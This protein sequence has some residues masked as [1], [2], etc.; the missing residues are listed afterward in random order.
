MFDLERWRVGWLDYRRLRFWA[1]VLIALYGFT[2]FVIVPWLARDMI[3]N[4][5]RETLGLTAHL[6]DVDVNPF[7]LS[8]R[9]E[10]FALDDANGETLLSCESLEAN[11]ELSSLFHR[12]FTFLYVRIASPYVN[13]VIDEHNKLNLA[14]LAPTTDAAPA[15]GGAEATRAAGAPRVLVHRVE[16]LGGAM[17]LEDHA[18]R[19]R[20]R[21]RFGPIDVIVDDLSTLPNESGEQ[22]VTIVG[23]SGAKLDWRGTVSLN[24]IGSTGHLSLASLLLPKLSAY[25]SDA[26]DVAIDDGRM[27]VAF[28]YAL[29][30]RADGKIGGDVTD[31]DVAVQDLVVTR[32]MDDAPLASLAALHIENGRVQWPEQAVSVGRVSIAGPQLHL[33]RDA[34]GR[35]TWN[36]LMRAT[37]NALSAQEPE[38]V[39][40][41]PPPAERN[42]WQLAIADV[43]MTGGALQFTDA[44][45]ASRANFGVE[46]VSANLHSVSLAAD[47]RMPF[48]LAFGVTG[49][50]RLKASGTF[51]FNPSLVAESRVEADSLALPSLQPYVGE[52]T[53]LALESGE[54]DLQGDVN[55]ASEEGVTFDGAAAIADFSL[56]MADGRDPVLSWQR[57]G[58]DGANVRLSSKQA[59]LA[60]VVLDRPFARLRIDRDG[61]LNV[62]AVMRRAGDTEV[63][64]ESADDERK[65]RLAETVDGAVTA[66]EQPAESPW[67]VRMTRF[68][69]HDAASDFRDESLPIVFN[70]QIAELGGRIDAFDSSSS[71]PAT[72]AMEGRV[73]DYGQIRLDGALELLDIERNTTLATHWENIELTDATPYTI[74][75]AGRK[76]E[77]GKLDLDTQYTLRERLLE[78]QHKIVLRDFELGERVEHPDAMDLPLD[79]AVSLL[80]GPDGNIDVDLPIKGNVDDPEFA[81]GGIIRKAIFSLI[82][83]IVAAPFRLL[84]A[85][86]GG[87]GGDESLDH[88]TFL[89]GRADLAPPERELIAKLTEALTLR[90]TLAV[91]VPGASAPQ[92][93]GL[94]IR[95]A[96]VVARVDEGVA[97]G[98]Q[99]VLRATMETLAS[100]IVAAEERATLR[101]QFT[102]SAGEGTPAVFDELAYIDA[103]RT[104]LIDAEPIDDSAITMLAESRRQAVVDALLANTSIDPS[105]VIPAPTETVDL[106]DGKVVLTFGAAVGAAAS[107]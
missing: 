29:D 48:E 34:E 66:A 26:L 32:G 62:G 92:A 101:E 55:V 43:G 49:G 22:H 24:P 7:A 17:D 40:P 107:P 87:G 21:Q 69:V 89:P 2:G 57:F 30:T 38:T 97:G 63:E 74:R 73:G 76:I 23:E 37:P 83:K 59:S 104:R 103:L 72:V 61:K 67:V 68:D 12:A 52:F 46:E 90:P 33:E 70:A 58:I 105:R 6:D 35:F 96:R 86:V 54:L 47:A 36:S 25:L 31:I 64:T 50:G 84:A 11:F 16:L 1:W 99:S 91:T 15:D 81:I 9:L 88:V 3:V 39:Q 18:V 79:L 65:S 42:P 78:G 51:G 95:T 56:V 85:L 4:T 10:Q 106:E 53:L 20:Y 5:V 14:V 44:S 75:F 98:D 80:R 94:A 100:D 102:T 41:Q 45:L 60:H 27:A 8:A 93:D 82:S 77:R 71:K 19:E 13:V 28:D